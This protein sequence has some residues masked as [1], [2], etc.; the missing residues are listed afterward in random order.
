MLFNLSYGIDTLGEN[1]DTHSVRRPRDLTERE[2]AA[3]VEN[4]LH[5]LGR[6]TLLQGAAFSVEAAVLMSRSSNSRGWERNA[7]AAWL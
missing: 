2:F 7:A 1:G 3:G 6:E 4:V 5:F